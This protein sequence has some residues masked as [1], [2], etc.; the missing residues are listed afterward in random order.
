MIGSN[1]AVGDEIIRTESTSDDISSIAW[2]NQGKMNILLIS[3]IDETKTVNL[4]GVY[5]QLNVN[6]IDNTIPYEDPALQSDII[7][8][9]ELL[10]IKGYSVTL[11][12]S[13]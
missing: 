10:I 8:A 7:G 4:Q 12:Q 6:W 13:S 1:L 11:L 3:K 9:N 2:F 5:G